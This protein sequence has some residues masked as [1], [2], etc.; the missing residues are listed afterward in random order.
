MLLDIFNEMYEA[1]DYTE[2]WKRSFVLFIDKPDGESLRPITLTSSPSKDC[3]L[4]VCPVIYL[5]WA[6]GGGVLRQECERCVP[7]LRRE[8]SMTNGYP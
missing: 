4:A 6:G 7:V 2:E 3:H 1:S 5:T 8:W